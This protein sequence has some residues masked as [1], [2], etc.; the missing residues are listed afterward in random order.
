MH[1]PSLE[2]LRHQ[3]KLTTGLDRS[4]ITDEIL[5]NLRRIDA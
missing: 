3:I 5:C 1:R 2:N 4:S